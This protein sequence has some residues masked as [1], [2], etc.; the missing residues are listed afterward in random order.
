[1]LLTKAGRLRKSTIDIIKEKL[2]SL[3][4]FTDRRQT[5]LSTH[6][7][8]SQHLILDEDNTLIGKSNDEEESRLYTRLYSSLCLNHQEN[9][10]SKLFF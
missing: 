7:L 10:T 4:G 8:E 5:R 9:T 3:Q 2:S 1:M 6:Y